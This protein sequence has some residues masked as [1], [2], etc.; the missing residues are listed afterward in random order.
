MKWIFKKRYRKVGFVWNLVNFV[1]IVIWELIWKH[2]IDNPTHVE[3][4]GVDYSDFVRHFSYWALCLIGP[5]YYFFWVLYSLKHTVIKDTPMDGGTIDCRWDK[6]QTQILLWMDLFIYLAIA[7][8]WIIVG[9]DLSSFGG[10]GSFWWL[11]A[12]FA[13][14]GFL[15]IAWPFMLFNI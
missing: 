14:L 12:G 2:V 9:A 10:D 6:T 1:V 7:A 13:F 15:M 3:F 11:G 5:A 8:A 4:N